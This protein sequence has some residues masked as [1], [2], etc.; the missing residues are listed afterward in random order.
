MVSEYLFPVCNHNGIMECNVGFA[1][2]YL[3]IEPFLP[4]EMEVVRTDAFE[5]VCIILPR[6]F[7]Y[8]TPDPMDYDYIYADPVKEEGPKDYY[9]ILVRGMTYDGAITNPEYHAKW[10]EMLER[11][12]L[13]VFKGEKK[14]ISMDAFTDANGSE[15]VRIVI[16]L[17]EEN[18]VYAE[19]TDDVAP[20]VQVKNGG[21]Y[22]V[23]DSD[24]VEE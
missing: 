20:F 21:H 1:C 18:Q 14:E 2:G 7:F 12:E 17:R 9:D 11:N 23:A 22:L 15:L 13:I 4:F 16:T 6:I 8:S 10:I 24:L 19:W 5:K 3:D